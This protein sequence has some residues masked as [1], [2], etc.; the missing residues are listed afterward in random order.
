MRKK[1]LEII[2]PKALD[3]KEIVEQLNDTIEGQFAAKKT[4]AIAVC[5]IGRRSKLIAAG[6]VM[7]KEVLNSHVL[8]A[9]PT[10]TGK[11]EMAKRLGDGGSPVFITTATQ[12]TEIGY[13][14]NDIT[15]IIEELVIVAKRK[16]EGILYDELKDESRERAI[17][18]I[19]KIL[20]KRDDDARTIAQI[21]DKLAKGELD[22]IQIEIQVSN[23]DRNASKKP[24]TGAGV[25]V[26]VSETLGKI[27]NSNSHDKKRKVT[28]IGTALSL[29]SREEFNKMLDE[30]AIIDA[31][32]QYA[33]SHG[34]IFIDEIDK[35]CKTDA[36][37]RGGVSTKGVQRD[38]LPLLSGTKIETKFGYVDTSRI[39]FIT[40]GAFHIAKKSDLMPELLGRLPVEVDFHSLSKENLVNILQNPVKGLIRQNIHSLRMS[41]VEL[42]FES[43]AVSAI[44]DVAVNMNFVQEDI[45]ARRLNTIMSYLLQDLL[46]ETPIDNKKKKQYIIDKEYVDRRLKDFYKEEKWD[47]YMI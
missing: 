23:N 25:S 36:S 12:Y 16:I 41:N 3:A 8:M 11:T 35:L 20:S 44:A 17:N 29:L 28:D 1:I 47:Q 15:S 34:I 43:S 42:K 37:Q 30:D 5:N 38:L 46:F 4:L 19:L 24:P 33:Q 6:D 9:G 13:V 2:K 40:A 39:L 14:G 10:G 31:A 7:A 32:L 18:I 45:G 22:D 27:F 26:F 21:R